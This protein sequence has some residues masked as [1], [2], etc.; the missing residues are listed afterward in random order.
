MLCAVSNTNG[1]RKWTAAQSNRA[2]ADDASIHTLYNIAGSALI[3]A[4]SVIGFF[5]MRL[6][7]QLDDKADKDAV[8]RVEDTLRDIQKRQEDR[9]KEN[10]DR[11]DEI[12]DAQNK[13]WQFLA[14]N[15]GRLKP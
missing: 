2:M 6:I 4:L 11:L 12:A 3:L 10:R 5:V 7:K 13:I 9:H 15:N 8:E 1:P 14:G